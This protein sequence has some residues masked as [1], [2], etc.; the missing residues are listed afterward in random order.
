[1]WVGTSVGTDNGTCVGGCVGGWVGKWVGTGEGSP[2]LRNSS[3]FGSAIPPVAPALSCRTAVFEFSFG[4][5]AAAAADATAEAAAG[6]AEHV[7]VAT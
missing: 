1:M 7:I 3:G 4:E 6:S 5:E 2:N